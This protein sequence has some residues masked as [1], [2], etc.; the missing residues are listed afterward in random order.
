MIIE[1][2]IENITYLDY[3]LSKNINRIELCDNLYV[4]GTT[5]SFGNIFM[6]RKILTK[7]NMDIEL[8]AIIRAR[9][10]DFL[11][12]SYEKELMLEDSSLFA[13]VGADRL[14]IGALDSKGFVDKDFLK[15]LIKTARR[16][17]SDIKFTFHMA[18]DYMETMEK[19]LSSIGLFSDL[20][21]DTV[22]SHGAVEKNDIF[23]NID[24]IKEYILQAKKYNINIMAGGGL[25]KDN[26]R[27]F[28]ELIPDLEAVHGT[29]IV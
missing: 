22:L 10:G 19:R 5:V 7:K 18:F 11:Y 3:V 29:K 23:N 28:L 16:Q 12:N 13:K 25:T 6:A 9:G 24:N 1:A 20:G 21:I 15:E 2:C 8:G 27:S 26:Y 17:N 14:V 4:G